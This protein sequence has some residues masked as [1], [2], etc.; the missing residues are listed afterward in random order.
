[1]SLLHPSSL[2]LHPSY[3]HLEVFMQSL[4]RR[5]D[6]NEGEIIH[7]GRNILRTI[8]YQGVRYVIKSFRVPNLVN[9]FVYGIFRASKA[10]RSYDHA[11]LLQSMGIGTPQPVGYLTT[12]NGLLFHKSYYVSVESE[13][14]HAYQELFEQPFDY[15]EEILREIGRVTARLH[16]S[17][18]AHK[19]YGRK[20]I[21]FKRLD[22]GVKIELVDLNRMYFGPVDMDMGCKNLERLPCTPQMHRWLA[23]EYAKA[24][25]FDAETCYQLM[26]KYRSRDNN[27]IEGKY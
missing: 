19:D 25:G 10:K 5:F 4:P 20:N 17:G 21:L 8:E 7:N 16:E 6:N 1:M 18:L 9:R 27:L 14:P 23:E 13:C 15:T 22:K 24:R 11:L 2:V 12:R 26:V 3:K